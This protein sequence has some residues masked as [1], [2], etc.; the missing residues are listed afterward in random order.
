MEDWLARHAIELVHI[1][2]LAW[3]SLALPKIASRAGIPVVM[4]FH[5]Y[6]AVC[7]S[8]K[9]L[10]ET[11]RYC[12]GA[13]TPTPGECAPDLW[14]MQALPPLK[15]AWVR[16]WR[17][18]FAEAF[19]SCDAF[20]TTSKA[21]T[22]IL[23]ANFPALAGRIDIIEHGRDFPCF[24]PPRAGLPRA[25][26]V[27]ILVPGNITAEKGRDLVMSL[28]A[29]DAGRRLRFHLLGEVSPPLR[30]AGIVTHGSYSREQ[31]VTRC[32]DTGATIGA[33]LS[34][35][36]ETHCHTLTELWSVGLPAIGLDFGAV[37]ER[38]RATGAGWVVPLDCVETLYRDICRIASD[39]EEIARA[40]TAVAAW[41]ENEGARNT[42]AAMA[43]KYEALY[44]RALAA[45][46]LGGER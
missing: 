11:G 15:G 21:A 32:L 28:A 14:T 10:D 31:F 34:K 4:S 13:C 46:A 45:R 20:V 27:D 6:Y 40:R 39:G 1:R 3:H 43:T 24:H 37:A 36:P 12:G 44:R 5:D 17:R 35:W 33:V 38:I 9:L 18:K 42:V 22:T 16:E 41:Q 19:T 2:H 29:L 7:P 26:P 8:L 25:E 23:E 30:G